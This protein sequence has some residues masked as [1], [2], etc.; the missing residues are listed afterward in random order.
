MKKIEI[1]FTH[2]K[3][4]LGIDEDGDAYWNKKKILTEQTITVPRLVNAAIMVGAGSTL[5]LAFFTAL[6]FI[7]YGS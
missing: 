6:R 3:G 5:A 4:E 7:G 2:D 1:I